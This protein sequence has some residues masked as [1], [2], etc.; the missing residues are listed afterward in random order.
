MSATAR[1]DR[2]QAP[3]T[4]DPPLAATVADTDRP[5]LIFTGVVMFSGILLQRF[6]IPFGEQF[7]SVCGPIGLAAAGWA[8]LAGGV[9]LHPARFAALLL[10]VVLAALGTALALAAAP[11]LLPPISWTSAAHFFGLTA[12]GALGF[13][14]PVD[15]S[16]FFAVIQSA[17]TLCAAM[18]LA[19]FA[20]QFVLGSDFP[21]LFTFAGVVPETFLIPGYNTTIPAGAGSLLKAN[22]LTLVEPSVLSQMAALGLMIEIATFRRP[23]R[24]VLFPLALVA[25]ASGTGWIVLAVFLARIA[26]G[27]RGGILVALATATAAGLALGTMAILLPDVFEAFA[28]RFDEVRRIGTSGHLRFVT[29]W[30][31]L[32]WAMEATPWAPFLGLGP[33]VAEKLPVPW[34]NAANVPAKLIIEY[35]VPAF[36]AYLA[37]YLVATRTPRQSLLLPALLVLVLFAGGYQQFPAVLFPALLLVAVAKL[38]PA[39]DA[40]ETMSDPDTPPARTR[41]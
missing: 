8:M 38:R 15:E 13:A 30:W 2:P 12:F 3:R 10:M 26:V 36:L 29:P 23:S 16:R 32:E 22:G 17:L 31:L 34:D 19:Q 24:L 21:G 40:A 6:A 20:A 25:S 9:T 5:A 11:D 27:K 39:G 4:A 35:G 28:E 33:G 14:R 1:F 41:A 37:L 18:A 7:I